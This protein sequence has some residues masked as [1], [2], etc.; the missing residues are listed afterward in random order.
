MILLKSQ[1]HQTIKKIENSFIC[2]DSEPIQESNFQSIDTNISHSTIEPQFGNS[3]KALPS[4]TQRV[5]SF[6]LTLGIPECSYQYG[7]ASGCLL[8]IVTKL[9]DYMNQE[10]LKNMKEIINHRQATTTNNWDS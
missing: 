10:D 8:L 5:Y 1:A 7:A 3:G 6:L 9:G 2:T 4:R